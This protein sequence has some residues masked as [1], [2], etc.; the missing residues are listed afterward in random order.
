LQHNKKVKDMKLA[1]TVMTC[2]SLLFAVSAC[3][4]NKQNNKMEGKENTSMGTIH[5]TKA[6]FLKKVCNYEVN[7]KEWKYEG[8][9]PCIVDFYATWC[10]PCKQLSPILEEVAK[11][12]EGK[13]N[14]YKIDVDQENELASV[15]GVRSIPTLLFIPMEGQP[16]ISQ[17]LISKVQITDFINNKLLNKK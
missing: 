6:D 14:V 7:N 15:F 16:T 17:G 4:G 1:V 2:L 5:L 10:G 13:I 12:Y 11:E 8:D 9:K 3:A